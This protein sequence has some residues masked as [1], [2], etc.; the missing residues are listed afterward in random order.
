ML[1]KQVLLLILILINVS[2]ISGGHLS[3]LGLELNYNNAGYATEF[4]LT[5]KFSTPFLWSDY[6]KI[7]FPFALHLTATNSIPDNLSGFYSKN[8][9]DYDC[10]MTQT[11]LATIYVDPDTSNSYYI[12]LLDPNNEIS[13]DYYYTLVLQLSETNANIQS[14]GVKAPIQVFTVSDTSSTA[15]IYDS[16]SVFC[17]IAL[18][19]YPSEEMEVSIISTDSKRNNLSSTYNV[20]LDIFPQKRISDGARFQMRFLQ[21]QNGFSFNGICES[22]ARTTTPAIDKLDSSIYTCTLDSNNYLILFINKTV[23]IN[24]GIR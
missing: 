18:N 15:I 8:F 10:G 16:N 22:L 13:L 11:G 20:T 24:M 2:M 9:G 17:T 19:D 4:R 5:F 6:L 21:Q 7:I 12:Q 1:S 23:E 14:T 3:S